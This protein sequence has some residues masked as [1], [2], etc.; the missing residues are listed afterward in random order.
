VPLIPASAREIG[1][2]ASEGADQNS[3]RTQGLSDKNA[4]KARLRSRLV[5]ASKHVE[6]I[7]GR[8]PRHPK[9]LAKISKR[10]GSRYG[11]RQRIGLAHGIELSVPADGDGTMEPNIRI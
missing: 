11:I 4:A 3:A 6:A 5:S 10:I 8:R 1:L 7:R 9:S 2:T